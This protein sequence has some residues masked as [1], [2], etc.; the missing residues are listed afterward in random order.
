MHRKNFYNVLNKSSIESAA[1]RKMKRSVFQ[2]LATPIKIYLFETVV[3][4]EEVGLDVEPTAVG[5][6]Y[7]GTGGSFGKFF[8]F[9]IITVCCHLL[10]VTVFF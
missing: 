7:C 10:N 8:F 4:L 6:T 9:A 2:L 3:D 5:R 1:Y